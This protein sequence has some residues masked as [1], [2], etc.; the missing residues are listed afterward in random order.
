M[1]TKVKILRDELMAKV[2]ET[3]KQDDKEQVTL[4]TIDEKLDKL[5]NLLT[6]NKSEIETVSKMLSEIVENNR[7]VKF[8][9][10]TVV[11][12]TTAVSEISDTKRAE[13]GY[14]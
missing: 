1:E 5:E 11:E 12:I 9:K 10:E 14:Y 3:M 4:N 2:D 8:D 13:L 7:P 6:E